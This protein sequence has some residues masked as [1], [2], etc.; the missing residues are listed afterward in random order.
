MSKSFMYDLYF[1]NLVPW[2]RGR[3]Q[4]PAYT[5]ITQKI[6]DIK[7]HFQKLLSP[8]EYKKFEEMEDLKAQSHTIEDVDLFE[9][10][11][12]M[13]VLMMID[14]FG[15]KEKRLTERESE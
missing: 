14:V 3:S 2:E 13:A 5:P 12:S 9:Y 4:D 11:F 1:G 10:A 7:V 15:F 8:E 6:N